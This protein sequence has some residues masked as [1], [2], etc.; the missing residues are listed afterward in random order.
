MALTGHVDVN[1]L[2]I[3][4]KLTFLAKMMT[5]SLSEVQRK[6]DTTP[7]AKALLE[8]CGAGDADDDASASQEELDAE[9]GES[10]ADLLGFERPNGRLGDA[11]VD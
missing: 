10:V 11:R 2:Q 6:A 8:L 7:K 9:C 3:Y 1:F 5:M 4:R